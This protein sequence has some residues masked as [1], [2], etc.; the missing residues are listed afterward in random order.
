MSRHRPKGLNKTGADY[1]ICGACRHRGTPTN[2]PSRKLAENRSCYVNIAQGVLIVWKSFQR[3]IYDTATGHDAIA[4]LGAGRMVRLGTYGD[5]SAVPS[6]IWESLLSDADGW[7]GYSH[8]SGVTGAD[9]RPDMVMR[10]ADTEQEARDAWRNGERTFRVVANV[11]DIIAGKEILCTSPVRKPDS[12]CNA[13]HASYA[14]AVALPLNLSPF[15]RMVPERI[16]SG[17][18]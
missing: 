16:I 13:M 6:F 3:G 11:S 2:D 8:Q 12:A 5:P 10:S 14:L 1:S 18:A 15:P 7:T 17:I 9:Y 4:K